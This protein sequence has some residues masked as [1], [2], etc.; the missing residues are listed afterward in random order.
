[1]VDASISLTGK[2]PL[3]RCK[4]NSAYFDISVHI[5]CSWRISG[6]LD[7]IV[8]APNTPGS[9]DVKG[10]LGAVCRDVGRKQNPQAP[11][12]LS[13]LLPRR[14]LFTSHVGPRE[15]ERNI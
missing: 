5:M 6:D 8:M 7:I 15:Q 13:T 1:M 14:E 2:N 11:P 12:A 3:H 4:P 10:L 9:V